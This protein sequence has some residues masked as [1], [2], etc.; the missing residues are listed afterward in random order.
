MNDYKVYIL[1]DTE[2]IEY[3]VNDDF[4]G[5]KGALADGLAPELEVESFNSEAEALAFCAG[6]GHGRNER[7]MPDIFP[8]RSFEPTDAPYITL[9]EELKNQELI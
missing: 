1:R 4:D 6:L 2:A 3:I 9:L 7:A 5:I 8:L